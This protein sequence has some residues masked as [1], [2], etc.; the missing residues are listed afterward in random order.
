MSNR[1]DTFDRTN[2]TNNIGTPSDGGSAWIQNAGTWGIISNTGYQSSSAGQ[3]T[4]TLETSESTGAAE[5]TASGNTLGGVVGRT[6]DNNNFILLYVSGNTMFLFKRVAGSLTQLTS[7]GITTS[8]PDTW[9]LGIDSS[10]NITGYLNGVSSVTANDSAGS[11][12]TEWGLHSQND[13][14]RFNDFSFTGAG[15]GGGGVSTAVGAVSAA[16]SVSGFGGKDHFATGTSSGTASA[17]GV[18]QSAGISQGVGASTGVATAVGVGQSEVLT[19]GNSAGVA[20]V[21]GVGDAIL[22]GE[23]V[24][25]SAG[26]ATVSGVASAIAEAV[27]TSAGASSA[28]GINDQ[29][30][31]TQTAVVVGGGGE[32]TWED[33][34]KAIHEMRMLEGQ[35][36]KQ[37]KELQKVEKQIKVAEK[38]FKAEKSEGILANLHRLEVKKDELENKIEALEVDLEPL[39]MMM[40]KWE[41]EEDDQEFMMMQ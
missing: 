11:T 28:D 6:S 3:D 1:T 27:G 22:P 37:K 15:G 20:S 4:C 25:T 38:K 14:I 33:H 19:V 10:N 13:S 41:I 16:A 40:D 26:I 17:A 2:T 35:V 32:L 8:L 7:A 12:N 23:T 9:K 18:G 21:A 5:V 34:V 39:I 24:G 31:V 29:V 36:R 30:V